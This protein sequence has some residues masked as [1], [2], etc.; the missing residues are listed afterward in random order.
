VVDNSGSVKL[1]RVMKSGYNPAP[2]EEK[3]EIRPFDYNSMAIVNF[4]GD[5]EALKVQ[6]MARACY[7]LIKLNKQNF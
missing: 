1:D 5:H 2:S 7:P 3:Y 6:M 4:F